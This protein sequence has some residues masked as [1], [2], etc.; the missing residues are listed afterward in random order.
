VKPDASHIISP[1]NRPKK[2]RE[3][4]ERLVLQ[5]KNVAMHLKFLT[6]PY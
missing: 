1:Y 5:M 3:I 6:K 4:S 2:P